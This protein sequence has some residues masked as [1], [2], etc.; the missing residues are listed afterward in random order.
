MTVL[1][2]YENMGKGSLKFKGSII[3]PFP[4]KLFK[5]FNKEKTLFF[6]VTLAIAGMSAMGFHHKILLS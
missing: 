1:A 3:Y 5:I 6:T 2:K 4:Q